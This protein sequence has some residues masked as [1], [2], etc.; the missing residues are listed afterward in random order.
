MSTANGVARGVGPIGTIARVH[1][2]MIFLSPAIFGKFQLWEMI[3]GLVLVPLTILALRRIRLIWNSE[4]IRATGL[5]GFVLN[6]AVSLA[7]YFSPL[8]FPPLAFTSDLVLIF[9][10]GSMLLAAARGYAGCEIT[11]VS[12]WLLGRVD[13]VGCVVFAP[14]DA[15]EARFQKAK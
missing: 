12:N 15:A 14:I 13:Q 5:W 9:Y 11:A 4:P 8:Y 6:L 10:G 1:L 7:L 3:V 2:G